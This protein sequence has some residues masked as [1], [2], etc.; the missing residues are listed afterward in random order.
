MAFNIYKRG[1]GKYTRLWSGLGA[2]FVA[3]LGCLQ[4]YQKLEA[5]SW[6]LSTRTTMWIATMVPAGLF[7]IL[8]LVIFW[9]VNKPAVADFMVAAEGEMK[10]V[11]WSSR[12]EIFVSTF[13]VIVVVIIMALLLGA[14]DITFSAFFNW[15]L[16]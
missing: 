9:L 12:Q 3:G 7:V 10:K 4:L 16:S 2:G 6:G 13:V 8:S 11:S 15:L 1:Q 14:T 5:A